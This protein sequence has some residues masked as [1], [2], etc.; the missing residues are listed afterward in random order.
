MATARHG[1]NGRLYVDVSTAAN[2]AAVPLD[3]L[4]DWSI[5]QS[6]DR[7]ETTVFGDTT[8][9]YVAGLRDAQG[10]FG[11]VYD[12]AVDNLYAIGDGSS[13]RFYLYPDR[14]NATNQYWYGYATFDVSFTGSVSDAVKVSGKWAAS[15][16]VTRYFV[17]A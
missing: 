12:S 16:S 7:V 17:A 5:D 15:T 9:T 1:R 2:A 4:T 10:T 13:R 3:G 6:Q 14:S 11:G 8:K